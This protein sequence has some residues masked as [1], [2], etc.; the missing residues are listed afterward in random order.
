M[1][2]E[3]VFSEHYKNSMSSLFQLSEE[4]F[5]GGVGGDRAGGNL[6]RP[7]LPRRDDSHHSESTESWEFRSATLE[8]SIVMNI[9]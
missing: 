5:G 7:P 3:E 6:H 1:G 2:A 9:N 4:S 8:V